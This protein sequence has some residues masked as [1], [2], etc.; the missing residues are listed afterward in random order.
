MKAN[1]P[2]KLYITNDEKRFGDKCHSASTEKYVDNDVEYI[3]TDAFIQKACYAYCAI[4]DTNCRVFSCARKKNFI[5][6][7]KKR[8]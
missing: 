3:R 7:L 4:C 5:E 6:Q 8:V 1:A 2:E